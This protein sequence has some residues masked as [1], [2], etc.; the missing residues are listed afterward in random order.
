M[1]IENSSLLHARC[2][3]GEN[4]CHQKKLSL[5]DV[6]VLVFGGHDGITILPS[7]RIYFDGAEVVE[8]KGGALSVTYATAR[9][10]G[11]CIYKIS[12]SRNRVT[13]R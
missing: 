4:I 7:L 6:D 9:V 2:C 11:V 1:I 10:V 12:W 8:A 13:I 5:V 3:E